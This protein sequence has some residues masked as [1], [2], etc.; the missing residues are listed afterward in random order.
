MMQSKLPYQGGEKHIKTVMEPIKEMVRI[1]PQ[2][3]QQT[4]AAAG[5]KSSFRDLF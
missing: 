3:V 4:N 5:L 1:P 2:K